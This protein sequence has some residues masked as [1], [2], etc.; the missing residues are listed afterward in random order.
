[1][2]DPATRER[3]ALDILNRLPEWWRVGRRPITAS[4]AASA[5]SRPTIRRPAPS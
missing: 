1:V 5:R 4:L 2:T 3:A